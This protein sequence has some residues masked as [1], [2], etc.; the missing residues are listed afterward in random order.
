[1]YNLYYVELLDNTNK[2]HKYS[3]DEFSNFAIF[4]NMNYD[5]SNNNQNNTLIWIE[6]NNIDIKRSSHFKEV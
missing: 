2:E 5:I 1:M 3:I 4:P 6:H